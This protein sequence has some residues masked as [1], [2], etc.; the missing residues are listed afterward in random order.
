MRMCCC[1][2][3]VKIVK[4]EI[5][6]VKARRGDAHGQIAGKVGEVSSSYLP[7]FLEPSQITSI[8]IKHDYHVDMKRTG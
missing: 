6:A 8:S 2:C 5:D 7:T 4:V 3:F 1:R